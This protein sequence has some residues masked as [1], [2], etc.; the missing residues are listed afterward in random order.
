MYAGKKILHG[1]PENDPEWV[2]EIADYVKTGELNLIDEDKKLIR[3]LFFEYQ[4][5]GLSPKDA[6][7]KAKDMFYVLKNILAGQSCTLFNSNK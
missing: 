7:R 3:E 6:I 2:K 5:D 1:S 4:R